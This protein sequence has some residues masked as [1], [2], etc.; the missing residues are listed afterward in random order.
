MCHYFSIFRGHFLIQAKVRELGHFRGFTMDL[1]QTKRKWVICYSFFFK[2][3]D[4][5]TYMY[6]STFLLLSSRDK[7]DKWRWS[8]KACYLIRNW[9]GKRNCTGGHWT[10]V[11]QVFMLVNLAFAESLSVL[12]T[13]FATMPHAFSPHSGARQVQYVLVE[14]KHKPDYIS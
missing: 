9:T 6:S 12:K 10:C 4:R 3:G 8:C 13:I 11:H 5:F 2:S 7:A 1:I 14:T